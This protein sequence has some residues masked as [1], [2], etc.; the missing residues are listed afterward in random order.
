MLWLLKSGNAMLIHSKDDIELVT[1]F[2]CFL[3]HPLDKYMKNRI[4]YEC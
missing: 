1:K 2:S 4:K 3:G